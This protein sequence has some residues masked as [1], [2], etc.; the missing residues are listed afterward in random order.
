MSWRKRIPIKAFGYGR[1]SREGLSGDT[2]QLT[3][4]ASMRMQ[5]AGKVGRLDV[6]RT[7]SG[8]ITLTASRKL[9]ARANGSGRITVRGNR[10]QRSVIGSRVSIIE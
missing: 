8:D 6:E 5:L 3:Q 9:Q 7:G 2:L 1:V 10:P 4:S